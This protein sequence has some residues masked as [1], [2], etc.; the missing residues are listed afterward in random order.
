MPYG[1]RKNRIGSFIMIGV[2]SI[3]AWGGVVLAFYAVGLL[4]SF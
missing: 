1:R 2:L 4:R 3:V